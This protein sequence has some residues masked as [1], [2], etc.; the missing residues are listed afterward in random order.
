MLKTPPLALG[1]RMAA[2]L[3]AI[4]G[5]VSLAYT[6]FV[7]VETIRFGA[8]GPAGVSSSEGSVIQIA[9]FV[10]VSLA[11]VWSASGLWRERRWAR[12]PVVLIEIIFLIAFAQQAANT[13]IEAW[14]R[15]SFAIISFTALV[16]LVC[17]FLRSSTAR[18]NASAGE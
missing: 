10:L 2:P 8:T 7:I 11:L 3:V 1:L 12:A 6:V 4:Q 15:A 14:L 5:I 9:L 13:D 17:V 18:F 16:T